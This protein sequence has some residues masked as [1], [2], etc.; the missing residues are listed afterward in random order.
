[1]GVLFK[2]QDFNPWR[3][4]VLLMVTFETVVPALFRS[5]TRSSRVVLGWSLTF[6]KIIDTPRGKILHWA[7]VRGK[8]TVILNFF[9]FLNIAPKVVA[10]SPSCM[11][12]V[13]KPILA[14]CRS[15]IVSLDMVLPIV[16]RL[17]SDW[18]YE[19]V[20]FIQVTS[21]DRPIYRFTDIFPDI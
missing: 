15:T 21:R 7:P 3:C 18:L 1:M 2:M 19:Q 4:S 12:I 14:L 11:P 13:L 20:S 16:E 5:L 9:H 17:E 6:L 10:F 8:L